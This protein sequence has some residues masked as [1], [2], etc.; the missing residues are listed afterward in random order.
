V[1]SLE[2]APDADDR[3]RTVFV[4]GDSEIVKGYAENIANELERQRPTRSE[5]LYG[6]GE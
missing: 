2:S 5:P 3:T 4:N 6:Y 1:Q